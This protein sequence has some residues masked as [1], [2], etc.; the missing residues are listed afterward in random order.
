MT[1][2][3]S[4]WLLWQ[5]ADSAFPSGGFAHSAGLEAANQLGEIS[6]ADDL[7]SF[8]DA[9]LWNVGRGG[10]PFVGAACR[11]PEKAAEFDDRLDLLLN[12]HVANRASRA[13]GQAMLAS[14][15]KAFDL[16]ALAEFRKC[17]QRGEVAGHLPVVLGLLAGQLEISPDAAGK[18]LIFMTLRGIV[19]AAVRSSI[20][21]PIQGQ[22]IQAE[23]AA[24][25]DRVWE[26]CRSLGI[27]DAAAAS[28]LVDLMQGVQDRLYSRLFMS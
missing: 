24:T 6:T 20:V 13:Q 18:L 5:L 25:A 16:P 28:P 7:K 11:E 23:C 2:P 21:G 8:I 4:D 1:T 22:S 19:S 26:T 14:A 10:V 27:D 9:S 3:S 12:H 17:S 15:A